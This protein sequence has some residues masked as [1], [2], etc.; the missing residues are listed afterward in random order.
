MK[1]DTFMR[2]RLFV[3]AAFSLLVAMGCHREV[4]EVQRNSI[5]IL[6]E[7]DVHCNINGYA[8]MAG[9]R[10]AIDDTAFVGVVSSGDFLQGGTV[11]AISQGGYIV[12]IM[13][14]MH[15]D[16]VSLGNHEFD[17]G[18][19]R[20]LELLGSLN[21]PVV[22]AN[23][24]DMQ[25]H[26]IYAPYVI[27]SYGD[28]KVAF[29][30]VVT[31]KSEKNTPY[32]FSLDG[33]QIYTLNGDRLVQLV[34]QSVNDA[35]AQGSD[36][37]VLLSHLGEVKIEN[38]LTSHELVAATTGIDVVLDAHT[39]SVILCDTVLN[40]NGNPVYISQTGTQFANV[41]KLVISKG[42][43][44]SFELIPTESIPYANR[45]VART[46]DNIL[47]QVSDVTDQ[48]VFHTDYKLTIYDENGGR[49]VRKSETNAGD[50]VADALR[51]MVEADMAFNN[52]GGFR[53][54]ILPGDVTY[55]QVINMLPYDNRLVKIQ[56]TGA[57]VLEMLHQCTQ[58]LPGESGEFPQ[59]SGIRF[60]VQVVEGGENSI[61][62]AEVLQPNGSYVPIN[63]SATYTI[64]LT[65]YCAY[66]G[67]FHD[68]FA[69]CTVLQ[70]SLTLY[71]DVLTPYINQV[72]GGNVPVQYA[73]P[74][75]RINIVGS[76]KRGTDFRTSFAYR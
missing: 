75:G 34:Q 67:G 32:S 76:K 72:Y 74:Q 41:G 54:E 8:K 49:A 5:V 58:N 27:R 45:E 3:F 17:F 18:M 24:Y 6:Y 9:L 42:G 43:D 33:Q 55:N 46:V 69:E 47:S 10:D 61:T 21:A 16:A 22:C 59:V 63:P 56:A 25:G 64:G 11:G 52:G 60:T 15:Y 50:L 53:A 7:N 73:Q 29:V 2:V 12:D 36:Y 19:P 62:S 14:K 70:S 37:V 51:Y 40:A 30:G 23:L 4:I 57:K 1:F 13:R 71:R 39:H 31:E 65:D 26:L 68:V 66:N 44:F 38:Y 48:V 35:R 28:R 20:Q